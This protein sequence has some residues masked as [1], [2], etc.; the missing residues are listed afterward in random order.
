MNIENHCGRLNCQCTHTEGCER[1]YIWV[2]YRDVRTVNSSEG[3]KEVVTWYDGV[4]FCK[5]C[6]PDRAYLQSISRTSDELQQRLRERSNH[7]QAE[8]YEKQEASKTRT[9]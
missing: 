5:I 3:K 7:K 1:G 8:N 2:R 4:H 6:D 9:L